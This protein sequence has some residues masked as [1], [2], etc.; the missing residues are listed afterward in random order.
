ME[1][2]RLRSAQEK[3]R[4]VRIIF[5]RLHTSGGLLEAKASVWTIGEASA[6]GDE[7]ERLAWSSGR[8]PDSQRSGRE[9]RARL[10]TWT[11]R[12]DGRESGAGQKAWEAIVVNFD[13]GAG[14]GAGAG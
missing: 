8:E 14:A 9:C 11:G 2:E 5:E 4:R 13:G 1:A 12:F 10:G 6:N 7:S 3:I